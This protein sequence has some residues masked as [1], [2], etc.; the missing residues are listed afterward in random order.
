MF[1]AVVPGGKLK[2]EATGGSVTSLDA[3]LRRREP[4]LP[5]VFR[6]GGR[7]V[8]EAVPGAGGQLLLL[9]LVGQVGVIL[10]ETQSR[11]KGCG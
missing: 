3:R 1:K 2:T 7:N 11:F 8:E 5:E 6:G 10:R 9:L 4:N